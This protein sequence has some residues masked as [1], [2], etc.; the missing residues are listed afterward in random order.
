MC[1]CGLL[2]ILHP[3]LVDLASVGP[4][5]GGDRRHSK[6]VSPNGSFSLSIDLMF[7]IERVLLV[8]RPPFSGTKLFRFGDI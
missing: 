7:Y 2:S 6:S 3:G 8:C 4:P 1:G 5:I